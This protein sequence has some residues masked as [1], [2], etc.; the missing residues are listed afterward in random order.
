MGVIANLSAK[1]H[2][3]DGQLFRKATQR[4][5][6]LIPFLIIIYFIRFGE[7]FHFKTLP[8]ARIASSTLG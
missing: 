8:M 3:C 2:G 6:P 7:I 1:L 5:V 4:F